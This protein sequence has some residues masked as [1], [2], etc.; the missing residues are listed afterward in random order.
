MN[1]HFISIAYKS[2][3]VGLLLYG[4]IYGMLAK[5]PDLPPLEQS[6]RNIFYHVP[7]WFATLFMAGTSL[8]YSLRYL[9]L[10]DPEAKVHVNPLL[11]DAK[12]REAALIAIVFNALGLATGIIW[13][14]VTWGAD[15]ASTKFTAWWAWDPVQVCA[16]LAL[17]I[18][19][20]YFLLRSSFAEPTQRAR[21]AAVYNIFAFATLIPL[22]FIIPKML[23][24]LHPTAEKGS[25]IFNKSDISNDFRIILYP[26]M[27]GFVLLSIWLFEVRSRLSIAALRLEELLAEKAYENPS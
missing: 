12:A 3:A 6:S 23:P 25:F 20:A 8:V 15:T 7:M 19:L 26:A 27:M 10:T 11:V 14:R 17:L 1:K 16:L 13:Q 9:R 5:L 4:I 24:G 18:Y 22:F 2:L 21:I